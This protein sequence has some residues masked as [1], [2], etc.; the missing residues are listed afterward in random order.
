[1]NNRVL[2]ELIT[3]SDNETVIKKELVMPYTLNEKQNLQYIASS[4]NKYLSTNNDFYEKTN[5]HKQPAL[6]LKFINSNLDDSF[7]LYISLDKKLYILDSFGTRL[8][9]KFNDKKFDLNQLPALLNK[10]SLQEAKTES[11]TFFFAQTNLEGEKLLMPA[12]IE[13][14]GT[15]YLDQEITSSLKPYSRDIHNNISFALNVSSTKYMPVEF[16]LPI[17]ST[18][19]NLMNFNVTKKEESYILP[20]AIVAGALGAGLAIGNAPDNDGDAP[21]GNNLPPVD[22]S[23]ANDGAPDGGNEGANNDAPNNGNNAAEENS[24]TPATDDS[25][26]P[27]NAPTLR[28]ST[29]IAAQE[30][31]KL[32][33]KTSQTQDESE[34]N[35]LKAAYDLVS[36][37]NFGTSI[38]IYSA[39][40]ITSVSLTII[41]SKC[42]FKPN[43]PTPDAALAV[44]QNIAVN[45]ANRIPEILEFVSPSAIERAKT[46]RAAAQQNNNNP[47]ETQSTVDSGRKLRIPPKAQ[48]TSSSE[49]SPNAAAAVVPSV[50]ISSDRNSQSSSSQ[51]SS[52]S[53]QKSNIVAV[54]VAPSTS[55]NAHLS[56]PMEVVIQQT[57]AATDFQPPHI[58]GENTADLIIEP[59]LPAANPRQKL[60]FDETADK[61]PGKAIKSATKAPKRKPKNQNNDQASKT[62]RLVNTPSGQQIP[63]S[64]KKVTKI[65]TAIKP[66]KPSIDNMNEDIGDFI[67]KFE[68]RGFENIEVLQGLYNFCGNHFV[69]GTNPHALSAIL[70]EIHRD[71]T[72]LNIDDEDNDNKGTFLQFF[73]EF[74]KKI[75]DLKTPKEKYLKSALGQRFLEKIKNKLNLPYVDNEEIQEFLDKET[76][77]EGYMHYLLKVLKIGIAAKI[78]AGTPGAEA[79][80]IDVMPSDFDFDDDFTL[81]ALDLINNSSVKLNISDIELEQEIDNNMDEPE[82]ATPEQPL[83]TLSSIYEAVSEYSSAIKT[84]SQDVACPVLSYSLLT[85]ISGGASLLYGNILLTNDLCNYV[86]DWKM[87]STKEIATDLT[88]AAVI[89]TCHSAAN[90]FTANIQDPMTQAFSYMAINPICHFVAEQSI[91]TVEIIGEAVTSL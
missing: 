29:R 67:N 63:L 20:I 9:G 44:G 5:F 76:H 81:E 66:L 10:L 70:N 49:Q 74:K 79:G 26:V 52:S 78:A 19:F 23:G 17:N 90:Q 6:R 59:E 36:N 37:I 30:Q 41:A 14:I 43:Q 28:R 88:E 12:T 34:S 3:S 25:T 58:G 32:D 47:K 22:N 87:P 51:S 91:N 7:A 24:Q 50:A 1:M 73:E 45:A 84:I 61:A 46:K 31:R 60:T 77:N 48:R 35:I 85:F 4:L 15:S 57:P 53:G 68:R 86:F 11:G 38:L 82:Q 2:N 65:G 42:F 27:N 18:S 69:I 33:S 71:D 89:S 62:Q 16:I 83:S 80:S 72:T 39:L 13:D 21:E 56:G 8:Y 64:A 54:V 75:E 40:T 55:S